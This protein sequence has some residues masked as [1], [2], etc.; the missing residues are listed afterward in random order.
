M[1]IKN[2]TIYYC[3]HDFPQKHWVARAR[4]A[5]KRQHRRGAR[6]CRRTTRRR[7]AAPRATAG[8]VPRSTTDAIATAVHRRTPRPAPLPLLPSP[9][10]Q[11]QRTPP[12]RTR[13]HAST[14][15]RRFPGE[16]TWKNTNRWVSFSLLFGF[17]SYPPPTYLRA[18]NNNTKILQSMRVRISD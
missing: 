13:M 12:T 11:P 5:P 14:A 18:Y 9:L 4:R 16:A 10:L 1:V 3:R 6:P 17:L 2:R 8:P 15:T 7:T